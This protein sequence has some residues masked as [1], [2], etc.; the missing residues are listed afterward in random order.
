LAEI[1]NSRLLIDTDIIIDHLRG[2]GE[3]DKLISMKAKNTCYI[4]VITI[5]EIYSLLYQNEYDIVDSLFSLLKIV[6][7]DPV[8]AKMAGIYRM[9]YFKSHHL[10]IPDAIIAASAKISGSV[11]ITKNLKHYP[12]ID[13]E[14]LKPY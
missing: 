7:V 13:I 1:I 9:K 3:L 10:L 5:S 8:I 6:N 2:I 14:K 12:M 4:S 11:L